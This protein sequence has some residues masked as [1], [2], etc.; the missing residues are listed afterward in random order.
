VQAFAQRYSERVSTDKIE[1]FEDELETN[2]EPNHDMTKIDD[3][4]ASAVSFP[5]VHGHDEHV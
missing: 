2:D 1:R 3:F 4:G 5:N